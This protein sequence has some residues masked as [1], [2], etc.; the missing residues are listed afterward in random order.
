MYVPADEEDAILHM[1]GS[2]LDPASLYSM[3]FPRHCLGYTLS[4]Y[5]RSRCY[6]AVARSSLAEVP[7]TR[8]EKLRM[9]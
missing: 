6:A 1:R 5:S 7:M 8:S 3:G 2:S 9:D 4:Y